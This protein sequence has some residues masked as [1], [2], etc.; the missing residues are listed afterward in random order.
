M[1]FSPSSAIE[2]RQFK[3]MLERGSI[4]R[5]GADRYWIDVVAYDID[6]HQRH[7]RDRL[8]LLILSF[9]L[10]VI[11]GILIVIGRNTVTR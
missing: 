1:A 9:V 6:V 4:R 7:R 10:T 11:F 3:K 2:A 5:E 8:V